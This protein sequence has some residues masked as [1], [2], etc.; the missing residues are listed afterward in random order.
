MLGIK[1]IELCTK[2]RPVYTYLHR[3]RRR[4]CH[5]QSFN[6]VPKEMGCLLERLGSE[7]ILSIKQ[8]VTI[9]AV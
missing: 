2:L 7:S 9:H 8:S 5:R 6:I 4:A 1:L 3:L